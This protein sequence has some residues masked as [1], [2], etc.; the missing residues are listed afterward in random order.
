M[1]NFDLQLLK[2]C[3]SRVLDI[4]DLLKAL[5][6]EEY[7][8]QE[9]QNIKNYINTDSYSQIQCGNSICLDKFCCIE[10]KLS[11]R[12]KG[13][14]LVRN[15]YRGS[16]VALS[17]QT[18]PKI[19]KLIHALNKAILDAKFD[20]DNIDWNYMKPQEKEIEDDYV[21]IDNDL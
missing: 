5:E 6:M 8:S 9:L 16:N 10:Q 19:R 11:R 17:V 4:K 12:R 13:I 15:G 7:I 14:A 21:I 18:L 1:T 2:H 20:L 3:L